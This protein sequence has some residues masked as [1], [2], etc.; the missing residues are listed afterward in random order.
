[1][2][3]RGEVLLHIPPCILS[4]LY[5]SSIFLHPLFHLVSSFTVT[6]PYILFLKHHVSSVTFISIH[7]PGFIIIFKSLKTAAV[8]CGFSQSC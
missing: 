4:P 2:V 1:M 3:A 6:L 7:D 5:I 8:G